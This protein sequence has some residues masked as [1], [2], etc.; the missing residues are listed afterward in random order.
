MLK[1]HVSF[2]KT[3]QDVPTIW[4]AFSP[5][6][7]KNVPC[8]LNELLVNFREKS[9]GIGR[10][11]RLKF[12]RMTNWPSFDKKIE[13]GRITRNRRPVSCN[14][15]TLFRLKNRNWASWPSLELRASK[16]ANPTRFLPKIEYWSIF[17]R[18]L[19]GLA[20]FAGSK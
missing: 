3:T 16:L 5:G 17:G 13:T 4:Q 1:N 8:P 15:F 18:N 14:S 20:D 12:Q 10:F 11:C 7:E 19:A 9:S 6:D 2:Q